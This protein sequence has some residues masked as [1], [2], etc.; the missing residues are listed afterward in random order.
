VVLTASGVL[1]FKHPALV[2]GA[3]VITTS[4][5]AR[6]IGDR[7]PSTCELVA[8]GKGGKRLDVGKAIA[9]LRTRGL[10]VLLSEGGPHV[11]GQ[12]IE[13]ELL[14]EAFLTISPVV[15]GRGDEP[16]LGMVAGIELL[17]AKGLWSKLLSA[18]R[19]GDYLFL[20]Y[21]FARS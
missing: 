1:D 2:R 3:I 8:M 20:R 18:R 7:L 13:A 16:R 9:E 5:G 17:P 21:G 6:K 10:D 19:H 4:A 14:D 11:V 15:A 12:L